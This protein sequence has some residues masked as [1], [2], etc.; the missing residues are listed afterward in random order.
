MMGD[1]TSNLVLLELGVEKEQNA[2][3][4]KRCLRA[5]TERSE[6]LGVPALMKRQKEESIQDL[7]S[8]WVGTVQVVLHPH[9]S[10]LLDPPDRL[11]RI[12]FMS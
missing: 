2:S 12:C 6:D 5:Q 10:E 7:Q 3:R 4:S 9:T 1:H 8:L 11:G